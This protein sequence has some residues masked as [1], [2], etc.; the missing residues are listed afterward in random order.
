MKA[1]RVLCAAALLCPLPALAAS[2]SVYRTLPD[3]PHAIVVKGVGDGR[4]DD[5]AAIQQAIDAAAG[6]DGPAAQALERS[7][8][9]AP[10]QSSLFRARTMFAYER[11]DRLTPDARTQTIYHLS[12]EYRRRRYSKSFVEMANALRNPAGRVG[13][14]LQLTALRLQLP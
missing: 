13:M 7:Y 14:A 10:L 6:L 12:A 8:A 11:W 3:D 2:N 4:T 5:S 9:V 1:F